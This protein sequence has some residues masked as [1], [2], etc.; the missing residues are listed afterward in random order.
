MATQH[1]RIIHMNL[2]PQP[3]YQHSFNLFPINLAAEFMNDCLLCGSISPPGLMLLKKP[4][5]PMDSN[6]LGKTLV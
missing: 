4:L 5:D 2:L 3:I 6:A 1:S